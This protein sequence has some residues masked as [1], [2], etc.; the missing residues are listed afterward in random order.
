MQIIKQLFIAN[1]YY[2][3]SISV[4]DGGGDKG[5]GGDGE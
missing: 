2:F 5:W 4:K 1:I 3:K